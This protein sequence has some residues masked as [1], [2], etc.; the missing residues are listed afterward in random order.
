[1]TTQLV[2][3]PQ[4]ES[5]ADIPAIPP[6]ETTKAG[7]KPVIL[8][9]GGLAIVAGI[10]V[11]TWYYLYRP[12][13][14]GLQLSG[15]IEG[16]ETDIGAKIPGRVNFVAVREGEKVTR[17]QV[18]AK[19]DDAEIQAQLSG[20]RAKLSATKQQVQQANLQISII[21][22]QIEE[23][24]LNLQQ[25]QGDTRGK[26]DQAQ[27]TVA[28]AEAQLSEAKAQLDAAISTVK[29]AKMTR[30]RYAKLYQEG[31]YNKQQYD[32]AQTSLETAVS[33]VKARQSGVNA[34]IKQVNVAKGALTQAQTTS[35]NPDIRIN[36]I[37]QLRQQL[38]IAKAQLNAVQEDV[39]SAQ[40]AEKQI[41]AQIAYLNVISPIDGVVTAR[42]VEPG[43]IVGSGKTLLT[44]INPNTVYMRG[45]IPE[46]E[47]GK[48]KVGTTAKVWLDSHPKKPFS[49]HV[50]AIDTQASFTPENIYFK[51]DRVRQV[52]GVKL[53]IDKPDGFAKPGMP[54]DADINLEVD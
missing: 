23:A 43:T 32:Q 5:Q 49:A 44:V 31:A 2:P 29:L 25:S 33:T 28:A 21:E 11:A 51:Q 17:G 1:M 20:A 38:S 9:L 50:S 46:G 13:A 12:V 48:V 26:I 30:D 19:L 35:F 4:D 3:Q 54:A 18:I 34:A 7:K 6:V 53:S 14:T 24:Q 39:K 36:K 40:A 15:R 10:C 8:L 45:Y 42:S 22:T 37:Q 47:I 16:Y 52:F 27:S 41:L